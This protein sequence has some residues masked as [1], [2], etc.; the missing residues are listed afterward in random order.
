MA[1]EEKIEEKQEDQVE[2]QEVEFEI[3][4]DMPE[5]D[6]AVLAKDKEKKDLLLSYSRV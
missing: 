2:S 6:R 5:E 1:T 4:D 3:E